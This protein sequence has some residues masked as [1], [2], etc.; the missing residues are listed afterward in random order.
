MAEERG[1]GADS[2]SLAAVRFGM[3]IVLVE[4]RVKAVRDKDSKKIT[5]VMRILKGKPRPRQDFSRTCSLQ[6]FE[7]SASK[8]EFPF[9]E[10]R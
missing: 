6:W 1:K 7:G 2:C 9:F 10:E 4:S 5:H 8:L 3:I